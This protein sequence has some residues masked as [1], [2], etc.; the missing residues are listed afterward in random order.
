MEKRPRGVNLVDVI[1]WP[2]QNYDFFNIYALKCK[3]VDA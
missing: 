2:Q 1:T 3:D